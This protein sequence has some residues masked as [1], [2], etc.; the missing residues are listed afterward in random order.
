MHKPEFIQIITY[1]FHRCTMTYKCKSDQNTC[2]AF[3]S[4]TFMSCFSLSLKSVPTSH[5][6]ITCLC[7]VCVLFMG[8]KFMNYKL[9]R[10]R[11]ISHNRVTQNIK[12]NETKS[13]QYSKVP[14]KVVCIF[15][16]PGQSQ[17]L[18]YKHLCH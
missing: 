10:H 9:R 18:L 3:L 14:E 4:Y 2:I 15:S 8:P 7:C 6:V 5:V 17:R 13:S 12:K 1:V 16:R 11:G